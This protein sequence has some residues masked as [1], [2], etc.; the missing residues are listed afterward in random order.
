MNVPDNF[1]VVIVGAGVSGIC[2]AKKLKDLGIRFALLFFAFKQITFELFPRFTVLEKSE[3]FGGTWYDNV[4][5]GC[6]CDVPS[7]LYSY[8]WCLNPSWSRKFSK[9]QEIL[10]YLQKTAAR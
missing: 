6:A 7:H 5:P 2:M 4:Y 1:H 8:S 3:S 9:Q 10:S